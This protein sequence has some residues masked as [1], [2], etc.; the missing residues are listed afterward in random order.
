ML[1]NY[2]LIIKQS[3]IEIKD[4][5]KI[6]LNFAAQMHHSKTMFDINYVN[7]FLR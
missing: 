6:I 2:L 7:E 4:E 1:Q 5:I 3:E